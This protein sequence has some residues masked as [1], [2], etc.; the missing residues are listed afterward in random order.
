MP[1]VIDTPMNREMMPDADHDSWVEPLEIADVMAF[2]CS[3]GASV[4]SGASVPVYGD[5]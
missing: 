4:T 1:S 5:A 2:L 3:D